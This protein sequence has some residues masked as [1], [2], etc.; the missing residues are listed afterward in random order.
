MQRLLKVKLEYQSLDHNG[1]ALASVNRH[2]SFFG[3]RFDITCA[4]GEPVHTACVAVGLDRWE[5]H[6][7]R[8]VT[9]REEER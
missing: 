5:K 2:G 4:S 6:A 7:A 1:L 8:P 3:E 9:A